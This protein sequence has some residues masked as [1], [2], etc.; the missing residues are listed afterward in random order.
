MAVEIS[1]FLNK[2]NRGNPQIARDEEMA[3]SAG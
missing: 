3:K 2:A 1:D